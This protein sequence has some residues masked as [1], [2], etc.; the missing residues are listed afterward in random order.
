MS[1]NMCR[2]AALTSDTRSFHRFSDDDRDGAM[3][4][5]GAKRSTRADKQDIRVGSGP[6]VLQVGHYR[7][8]NLLS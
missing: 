4:C 5:E 1:K 8:S 7:I 2:T 3:G 6:A